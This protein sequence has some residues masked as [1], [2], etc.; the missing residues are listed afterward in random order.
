M[1]P[2]AC[3]GDAGGITA[4]TCRWYHT[5]AGDTTSAM[6]WDFHIEM[7]PSDCGLTCRVVEAWHARGL[8]RLVLVRLPVAQLARWSAPQL[9]VG[10]GW[11][12]FAGV[13]A[14]GILELPRS[15]EGA[16]ARVSFE[17]RAHR[18]DWRRARR[19]PGRACSARRG[20]HIN[21]PDC[22]MRV[23]QLRVRPRPRLTCR[24]EEAWH[25]RGLPR[26]VLVRLPVAQLARWSAP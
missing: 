16:L 17:V 19:V 15:A 24:V 4:G 1:S 10:P 25:A 21:K 26:L 8:P 12:Q 14:G 5:S 18:A 3:R 20:A 6:S 9:L 11:T 22:R 7:L 23:H 2:L 13:L